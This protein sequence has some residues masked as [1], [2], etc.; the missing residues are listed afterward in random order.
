V[1]PFWVVTRALDSSSFDADPWDELIAQ[2][3]H[4]VVVSLLA[5]G[6]SID[7][8][9]DLAQESWFRLIM[10]RRA[11]R[12]ARLALPGLAIKQ[13]ALLALEEARRKRIRAV[14]ERHLETWVSAQPSVEARV[15]TQQQLVRAFALLSRMPPTAQEVFRMVYDQPER[16]H[17]EVATAIGLSVQ[18]VRQI[19][20]EVRKRLRAAIEE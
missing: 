10:Q 13:A 9:K 1:R 19:L 15:L 8:A 6:I 2:H 3:N 4:R 17:A 20:C 12:L 5:R 14:D 7:R 16:S 11:G 18:R